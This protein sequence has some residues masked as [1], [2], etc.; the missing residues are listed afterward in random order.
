MNIK[1]A[2]RVSV[3][4]ILSVVISKAHACCQDPVASFEGLSSVYCGDQAIF[5]CTST[6]ADSA[7]SSRSWTASGGTPSTGSGST[8]TTKWCS[9]GP[10]MVTL[11][12]WDSDS[13][14]GCPP[15]RDDDYGREVTVLA[16]QITDVTS[17]VDEACV[18]CNIEFEVITSPADKY[19]CIEWSA[20]GGDP[21]TGS[22]ETFITNWDTPGPKTVTA[23]GCSN[24]M[25]KQV[26]VVEVASLLPDVGTEI[27]DGDNDPN[28]K[29]FVICLAEPNTPDPNIIVTA[30]P[31]PNVSEPNLPACWSLSG[32]GTSKLERAV[33]K[34]TV[35]AT[36][37]TC[38]CNTSSKQTTIYVVKV[39][40]TEPNDSPVT[41][42][43]FVFSGGDG[44]PGVCN[45]TAT[46]TTGV[47]I[48]DPNLEW[49]LTPIS[50]STLTW[51]DCPNTPKGPNITFTY[52]T[53]PSLNSQFGQKTL[54]L[55]HPSLPAGCNTDTQTVE[56]YYTFDAK[57]WPGAAPEPPL[58]PPGGNPHWAHTRTNWY[59]YYSQTSAHVGCTYRYDQSCCSPD[60][61]PDYIAYVGGLN[62]PH[63]VLDYNDVRSGISIVNS[64]DTLW[65]IDCF[66]W[67]SRHEMKHH[68]DY[69]TWW[70]TLCH[71]PNL[72]QDPRP[73]NPG[74]YG[75]YIPDALESSIPPA[76]GGPFYTSTA[77]TH[78]PASFFW[79]WDDQVECLFS[80]DYWGEPNDHNDIDWAYPGSRWNP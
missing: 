3:F 79:G 80:Q 37:I 7:I 10:K 32:S 2:I 12:V 52:T 54:S 77:E 11:R 39:E 38:T 60:D 51:P 62:N 53:L 18:G 14:E 65:G 16:V 26:T 5:T 1:L 74:Y 27:D 71:D 47:A 8:F 59:Y 45:V 76:D 23:T 66:A 29:S 6:D 61:C 50:G 73:S 25:D 4:T 46:G 64:D 56:I 34:T 78:G 35:G 40:I 19:G 36:T 48:L 28:T 49:T 13:S 55:T 58:F 70:G 24:S 67:A 33:D 30:T 21:S 75:D 44:I 15:D 17:D 22:G 43:R 41:D 20:P 68:N 57:N 69:S 31:A 63:E 9:T 72:D 42:N